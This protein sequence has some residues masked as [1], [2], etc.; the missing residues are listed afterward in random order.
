MINILV[1]IAISGLVLTALGILGNAISGLVIWSWLTMIFKIFRVLLDPL[2]FV[3]DTDT[4]II[5]IGKMFSIM[6]LVWGFY[7]YL[8]IMRLFNS[9]S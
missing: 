4:L 6:I 1:K 3:F 5:I 9:K 7:G 2:S 8:Y